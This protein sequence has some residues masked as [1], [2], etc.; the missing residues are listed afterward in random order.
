MAGASYSLD[1]QAQTARKVPVS[2]VTNSVKT[3]TGT[4]SMTTTSTM[5]KTVTVNGAEAAAEKEQIYR[6]AMPDGLSSMAVYTRRA[7][8][9]AGNKESLGTQTM[10]GVNAEGSRTTSTI[11]AGAVGNDRPFQVVSERWNSLDLQTVVMTRRNDPRTGEEFRLTNIRRG[12]P[13]AYLFQVPAG[14]QMATRKSRSRGV[15]GRMASGGA[16]GNRRRPAEGTHSGPLLLSRRGHVRFRKVG[17]LEQK[18]FPRNLR[19]RIGA[20]IA[21]IQTRGM[22]ALPVL[23]PCAPGLVRQFRRERHDIDLGPM[24]QQ[25]KLAPALVALPRFD[26][27]R[28]LQSVDS[29][30]QAHRV[31]GDGIDEA[32]KARFLQQ[33]RNNGRRVDHHLDYAGK[34]CSSK[35][36][37]S[38]G[39]RL[40]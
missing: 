3:A 18:R 20:A 4:V 19:K 30:Y 10:E 27:N 39:L 25:V 26:Y 35:P 7:T 17:A 31:A 23:P 8:G 29:R 14:Y 2:I 9:A 33:N 5:T 24:Q 40:S 32:F 12:E 13:G 37:I 11:E 34:P 1:P 28:G 36:M 22:I 38:S 6:L 16:V 15:W 21:E